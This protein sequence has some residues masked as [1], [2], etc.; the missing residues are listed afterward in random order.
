MRTK[1]E[2]RYFTRVLG[3]TLTMISFVALIGCGTMHGADSVALG[4]ASSHEQDSA[5]MRFGKNARA[6]RG[7][8]T[9]ASI[10]HYDCNGVLNGD[11][12]EQTWYFDGDGLYTD[13]YANGD[14]FGDPN[15][16][17]QVCL[18]P[19]SDNLCVKDE[20][21]GRMRGGIPGW[22]VCNNKDT[23]PACVNKDRD[24]SGAIE[25]NEWV[26]DDC[27][28]CGGQG[29]MRNCAGESVSKDL[30]WACQACVRQV[31]KNYANNFY[32]PQLSLESVLN[33]CNTVCA[34]LPYV[35]ECGVCNDV[36]TDDG[37]CL[38]SLR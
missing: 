37:M 7:D 36:P 3:H 12:I 9:A 24:K 27:G 6:S 4:D 13:A 17:K 25:A 2:H 18:A 1:R 20:D 10:H 26:M 19:E 29:S 28:I 5:D 38:Q 14:G 21:T 30:H 23:E 11:A 31:K 34:G 35:D 32:A 15:D 22:Y 8:E 33:T 16:S